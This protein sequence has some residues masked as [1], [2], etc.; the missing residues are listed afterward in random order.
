MKKIKG[1]Q[2]GKED[3][4]LF[5]FTDEKT[6]YINNPKEPWKALLEQIGDYSKVARYKVKIQSQLLSYLLTM[7][8]WNVK[9]KPQ[10]HF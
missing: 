3:T 6:L 8:E 1:I 5:L 2:I 4:T 7:N 9:I 10:Y